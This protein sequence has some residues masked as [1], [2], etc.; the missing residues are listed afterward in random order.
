MSVI[1]DPMVHAPGDLRIDAYGLSYAGVHITLDL[2]G[3]SSLDDEQVVGNA[4]RKAVAACGAH[5]L[6]LKMHRFAPQGLTGVAI[7]SESHMSIH[8]W[9]ENNY[10]AIDVFTCGEADPRKAI[11]ILR[12]AFSPEHLQVT[13]LKRG[14]KPE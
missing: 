14:I 7:L 1:S 11:P 9:P 2:W 8:C 12:D 6:E 5:L 10:A 13:E 4:L 3:A